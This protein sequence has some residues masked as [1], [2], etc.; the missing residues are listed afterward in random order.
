MGILEKLRPQPRWK[1]ADPGVRAAAVYEL[2]PDE[3][4]ALRQLAREDT[5][6]RVRR[7]AVTRLSDV[8]VLGDIGRTD[9]DEDVRAE[10]I[11]GLAGLA[12]EADDVGRAGE[13]VRQLIALG[14]L[15][16][17]VVAAREN[18]DLH[19][20]SVVVDLLDDPKSLGS[21]SR[22]AQDGATR[23][24]A[25]ARLR[26][27]EEILNVA[28]KAEHTDVAVSALDRVEGSEALSAIAQR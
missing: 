17:V 5:E 12:A 4:E 1:H 16:E 7:A 9:P 15:K 26:D 18:Q 27:A 2:G 21:I 11:R 14:R 19:I 20:R 10:A 8:A 24:R 6:A 28:L 22:H 23:L 3:D 13:A 25:L